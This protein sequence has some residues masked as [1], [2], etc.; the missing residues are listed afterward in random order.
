MFYEK[1]VSG[2]YIIFNNHDLS[3]A[4]FP[5][6]LNGIFYRDL[7]PDTITREY[8][9]DILAVRG[10]KDLIEAEGLAFDEGWESSFSH[11]DSIY[12]DFFR[13]PF[14]QA[15]KDDIKT[16][17][18]V[19]GYWTAEPYSLTTDRNEA[20]SYSLPLIING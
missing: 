18:S 10:P 5:A 15:Y 4:D 7:D 6:D 9:A 1:D 12:K 14:N 17:M 20:I 8:R 3:G 13:V 2:A 11:A 19:Y 16:D